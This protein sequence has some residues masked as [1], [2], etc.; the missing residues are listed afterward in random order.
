MNLYY[1]A[2]ESYDVIDGDT[3]DATIDLGFGVLIQHRLRLMGIN[4]P[5]SHNRTPEPERNVGLLAKKFLEETLYGTAESLDARVLV[6]THRI[7][8]R[9]GDI[10]ERTGKYGRYM[11]NLWLASSDGTLID[12]NRLMVAEGHANLY[13]GGKRPA[14]G[15][16][17]WLG[18]E[19]LG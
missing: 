11:V 2:L 6:Q 7:Q 10:D 8:R 12:V 4:T 1:Y 19:Q 16:W 13:T 18:E 3:I 17:V 5:E 15:T 9:T 14:L